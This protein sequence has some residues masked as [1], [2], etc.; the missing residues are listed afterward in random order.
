M[1]ELFGAALAMVA[2]GYLVAWIV[3]KLSKIPPIP[4][5]I[6]G[7][8][9]MTV[10]AGFLYSSGNDRYTFLEAWLVYVLGGAI[11]L[12]VMIFAERRRIRKLSGTGT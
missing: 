3:R 4:S 8:S 11:A 7:V 10:V 1:A 12:P 9:L 5:F 2:F 6:V